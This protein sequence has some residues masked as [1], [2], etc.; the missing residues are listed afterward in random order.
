M[1]CSLQ[2]RRKRSDLKNKRPAITT[3][4]KQR[5]IIQESRQKAKREGLDQMQYREW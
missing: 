2:G 4:L 1:G 5:H 3:N